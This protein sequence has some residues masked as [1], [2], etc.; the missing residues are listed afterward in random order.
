MW[1]KRRE[2]NERKIVA[3]VS[4]YVCQDVARGSLCSYPA[5]RTLLREAGHRTEAEAQRV[6]DCYNSHHTVAGLNY[7]VVAWEESSDE[8][9]P[10]DHNQ[11]G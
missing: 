7:I 5:G 8:P 2:N 9:F 6:A 1:W 10:C 3:V 4:Y 11:N